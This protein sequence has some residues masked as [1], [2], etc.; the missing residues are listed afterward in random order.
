MFG[1]SF[2][3]TFA[4][5]SMDF[6]KTVDGDSITFAVKGDLDMTT[7]PSFTKFATGETA[8]MKSITVDLAE[9]DY[10][11]SAG[12]RSIMALMKSAPGA[13]FKVINTSGLVRE[14]FEISGFD[15]VL[16]D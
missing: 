6:K 1:C 8:G 2:I 7:S 9:L 4:S 13:E 5:V 11:S 3:F 10:I 14:V 15:R 16:G 12:L